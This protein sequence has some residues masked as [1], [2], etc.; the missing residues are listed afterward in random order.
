[1][2]NVAYNCILTYGTCEI[3]GSVYSFWSNLY[4]RSNFQTFKVL[5]IKDMI[6]KYG[7]PT[8]PFKL[9]TGTKPSVSQL[10]VLFFP[11]VV[12]KAIEHIDIK[13]LN[14]FH[15]A[16]KGFCGL[17]VGITQNQKRYSVYVPRRIGG[18]WIGSQ[19]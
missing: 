18:T 12:R 19:T 13:A 3:F 1:M 14:T 15:Q 7:E 6:N 8:T 4:V 16:Q 10:R 9:S 17:F 2:D 11:C 5:P